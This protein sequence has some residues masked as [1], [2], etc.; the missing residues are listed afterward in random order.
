MPIWSVQE[1]SASTLLAHEYY[2][3]IDLVNHQIAIRF[4][5]P[6]LGALAALQSGEMTSE[7]QDFCKLHNKDV[8]TVERQLIFTSSSLRCQAS[9]SS[10]SP[11]QLQDLFNA[12][13]A[14]PELHYMADVAISLPVTSSNAERAFSK[15][16]LIKSHLRTTMSA[17]RLQSLLRLSANKSSTDTIPLSKMLCLFLK[18]ERKLVF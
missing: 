11:L 4:N 16:R 3:I 12:T 5:N 10:T 7:L 8:E 9:Q 18:S 15:L 17:E 14:Q 1:R 13:A 2:E 6:V